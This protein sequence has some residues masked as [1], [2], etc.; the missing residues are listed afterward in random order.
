MREKTEAEY[1]R[2]IER[3][4]DF[5]INK[6]REVYDELR[7]SGLQLGYIKNVIC[8]FKWKTKNDEYGSII[9]ELIEEI[10]AIKKNH[11]NKFEKLDWSKIV[12]PT[13]DTTNDLIKG[14]YTLFPPR[15]VT[16]YAY[17]VYVINN[18]DVTNDNYNYY[19]SSTNKF[20]F[21]NYKTVGKYKK[22][23]FVVSEKLQ[24]LIEK[25]VKKQKIGNGDALLKFRTGS[26]VFSEQSLMKRIKK[27]FGTSVDGIRHSYITYL[28]KDGKNLFDIED[29]SKKMAHDIRTHLT[30]LDKE[31]NY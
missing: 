27:I 10:K 20:I 1:N 7:K 14:L 26:N 24:K 18:T 31:N 5:D 8:A 22:Q 11:I 16:D 25:Y 19:V 23:K 29:T 21:Q 6:P 30:Y 4:K 9:K 13:G 28:Y 12:E 2:T 17:M 3:Y 15:R